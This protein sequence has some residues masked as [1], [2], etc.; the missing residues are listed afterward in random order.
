M[1]NEIVIYDTEYWTDQGVLDRCW[2]GIDDQLP[3]LI[4]IGAYRVKHEAGLPTVDE[5][6][7]FITP[8]GRNGEPIRLNKYFCDLTGITQEKVDN[9]G[10]HPTEAI[11]EFHK[12]VGNC[13]MYSYG[14]DIVDTFLPTCFAID[15]KCPF[16]L[17]QAKDA[18]HILRQ[19]GVTEAEISTNRSG[20]I[21]HHFGVYL[22][23]HHEHDAKDDARS[24]LEAFRY[25]QKNDKLKLDWL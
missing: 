18:R 22:E 25:L 17:H 11:S 12:F 13:N 16:D 10:R 24:L 9:D 23:Q 20:S 1:S 19:A 7:S 8:I 2:H 15:I 4:Q 5:M 3:V 6:L 21:A 14:D